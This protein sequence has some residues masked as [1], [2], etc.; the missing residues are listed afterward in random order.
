MNNLNRLLISLLVI[1]GLTLIIILT[2]KRSSSDL[3]IN[4]VMSSNTGVIYDED[5]DTP[6]WIEI[7]NNGKG[8][9]NLGNYY[10][11][12]KPDNPFEWKFPD[13]KLKPKETFIV[14]A[15]GKNRLQRP[16]HQYTIID[17]AQKW[18]Y[19]LPDEE[20]DPSWKDINF[21][22]KGWKTGETGLFAGKNEGILVPP[23]N[24][25]VFMRKKFE[26]NN[27]KEIESLWF[28]M[29]Y[30][31]GFV[32]YINGTE[33]CRSQMGVYGTEVLFNQFALKHKARIKNNRLPESF[34]ITKFI[35]LLKKNANV[36][37]IEVHK[38]KNNPDQLTTIPF[39]TI[40]SKRRI[41]SD[42]N[43]SEYFQIPVFYPHANFKLSSSGEILTLLFKNGKP[44]DSVKYQKIPVNVSY[45]RNTDKSSEWGYFVNATP[46]AKNETP[47]SHEIVKNIPEYSIH[48]MFLKNPCQLSISGT[49]KDEEIR[50]TL[51]G[52]EPVQSNVLYNGPIM[53][54]KN[55]VICAR[56]FKKGAVPGKIVKKT[57]LFD[58]P[59][60]LPV[61]SIITDPLNLWDNEK[62]IY[63]LGDTYQNE[64]PYYGANFWKDWEKSAFI[65]MSDQ[66]NNPVFAQNCGIKIFGG[67]SRSKDQ[68]SIAVFFRKEYGCSSLEGIKLFHSK[69]ITTFKSVVL[70]NSG[71]DY[72]NSRFRDCL[73]TDLVKDLDNDLAA[74]EPVVLYI[75]GK[76]WGHLNLREKINEDYLESNHG[77][78]ADKIDMLE[79]TSKILS[80]TNNKYLKLVEFLEKNSLE[81]DSNYN[82]VENQIDINNFSDYLISQIY[83]NNRD[84]PG[85]NLKYWKPQD[86][87]GKWR[88]I[89]Y[90]TDFGFALDSVSE[91]KQN[92]LEYALADNGPYWPNPPW[93]T[94]LFRRLIEN[95]KF[96]NSFVNRFA[97]I[98]NTTF[99]SNKVILKIDSIAGLIKPEINRHYLRWGVPSPASWDSVVQVLK[100]FAQNRVSYVQSHIKEVLTHGKI[101][102]L[103]VTVNPSVGGYIKLNSINIKNK[104]WKGKYF[105][106]IPVT[107]SAFP[108]QGYKFSHWEI[109]G[110]NLIQNTVEFDLKKPT[111]VL[112]VF[113]K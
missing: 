76:Y 56:I 63:V 107:F 69:P 106:N 95:E 112:A 46:L 31:D 83:F 44:A 5:G 30:E 99:E 111:S 53:L 85:N 29:D 14:F 80:G 24:N 54:T 72:A 101:H 36:L 10:L 88:W 96:K 50:Y 66:Y 73:M 68:K 74:F 102:E 86:E 42:S 77:V 79:Y 38:S 87:E 109:N 75:N 21:E 103:V 39:L 110:E 12:V 92:S 4:E 49:D 64:N 28:H 34:N 104:S 57:F 113:E 82:I 52:S 41:D 91:Y 3:R 60:T 47:V 71:N 78:K 65:E 2:I 62:G 45:G 19:F 17:I 93:A 16:L 40:G 108:R 33:V 97:D 20:V 27:L 55:T 90:D 35:Y 18:N 100:L 84:W 59:P 1:S 9:V 70:R 25:T 15:S 48:K 37:A 58:D 98:L 51:D 43:V 23:V 94:L 26:I 89:L 32:A 81:N 105:E 61:I 7:I 8:S 22:A 6:D 13:Y 67:K 11:T